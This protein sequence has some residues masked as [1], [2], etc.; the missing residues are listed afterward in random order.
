MAKFHGL[1][2]QS[3][4][5]DFQSENQIFGIPV[6]VVWSIVLLKNETVHNTVY[7]LAPIAAGIL[8][9]FSLKQ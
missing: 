3:S 2:A 9:C 6:I 1:I 7:R 4:F 5:A 8:Y